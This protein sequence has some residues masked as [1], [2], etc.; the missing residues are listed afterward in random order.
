MMNNFKELIKEICNENNIKYKFLSKD[1]V[2]MLEK[3][4][5]LTFKKLYVKILSLGVM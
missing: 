5:G 1:W 3:T 4:S 2:I